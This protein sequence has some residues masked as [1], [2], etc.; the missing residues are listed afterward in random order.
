MDEKSSNSIA[1]SLPGAS[2]P[3][4]RHVVSSAV[5]VMAL[6]SL[7][8]CASSKPAVAKAPEQAHISVAMDD[9]TARA[10]LSDDDL[11]PVSVT[12]ITGADFYVTVPA[13]PALL[14]MSDELLPDERGSMNVVRTWGADPIDPP[15]GIP[16]TRE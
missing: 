7:V 15:S 5:V 11:I 2:Y 16:D 6:A 4:M 1:G 9:A 14:P 13:N 8:G 10:L 3:H 12:T